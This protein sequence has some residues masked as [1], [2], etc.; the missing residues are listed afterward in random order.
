MINLG[1]ASTRNPSNLEAHI[2][3]A[4]CLVRQGDIAGAEWEAE[5]VL[6]IEPTFMLESFWATYPMTAQT[7]I[8]T[9]SADVRKAGLR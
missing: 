2:Y 4:A 1:E 6:S 7:Q 8:K 5:E 9:L 3:M